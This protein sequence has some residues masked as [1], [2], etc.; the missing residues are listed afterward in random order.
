MVGWLYP[1]ILAS[2]IEQ[3]RTIRDKKLGLGPPMKTVRIPVPHTARDYLTTQ[4]PGWWA[5]VDRPTLSYFE[6]EPVRLEFCVYGDE[7]IASG[8]LVDVV[9]PGVVWDG[10]ETFRQW[11][12]IVYGSDTQG[13]HR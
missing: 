6:E 1:S 9:P 11:W 8:V 4:H 12:K 7:V 5:T 2:E 3:L 10:N 13:P